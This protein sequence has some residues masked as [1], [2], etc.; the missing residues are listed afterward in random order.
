M[1]SF[2]YLSVLISIILG[3]GVAH[4]LGGFAELIK[5]RKSLK[6]WLP[7]P[8]WMIT[9]F[10]IHVQTWWALFAL[11]DVQNWSFA[12]FLIVL[13]QPVAL[14]MMASL[15]TPRFAGD[16]PHDL[17]QLYWREYRWFFAFVLAALVASLGKDLILTGHLPEAENLVAHGLFAAVAVL[18]FLFRSRRLQTVFSI[19]GLLFLCAYI[20][21]LFTALPRGN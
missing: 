15:I 12:A 6:L 10:L 9:I 7:T 4:L 1:D 14:F 11:R 20:A 5:R 17:E 8:L 21:I 3:L 2:S 19:V 18:A 13:L 16:A